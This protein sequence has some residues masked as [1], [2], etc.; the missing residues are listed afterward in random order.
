MN[1]ATNTAL[2]AERTVWAEGPGLAAEQV[3]ALTLI[4]EESHRRA[5]DARP[6]LDP[7]DVWSAWPVALDAAGQGDLADRVRA[8]ESA[9]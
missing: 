8:L 7:H 4:A 9:S 2:E 1:D 3:E 6:E 5:G